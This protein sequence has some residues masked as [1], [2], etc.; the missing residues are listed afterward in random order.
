MSWEW[1]GDYY[2]RLEGR[3][4]NRVHLHFL[5]LREDKSGTGLGQPS[6]LA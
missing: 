5:E 2:G 6:L 3:A 1:G 4:S